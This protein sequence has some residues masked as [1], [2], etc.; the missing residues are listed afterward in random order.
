M[1]IL[2][3]MHAARVQHLGAMLIFVL[4]ALILATLI[5]M[6]VEGVGFPRWLLALTTVF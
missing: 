4:A 6:G 3:R 1:N 5:W 2:A